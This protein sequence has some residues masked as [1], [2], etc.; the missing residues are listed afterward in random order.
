MVP[1][2]PSDA[3]LLV[4]PA[5]VLACVFRG[6]ESQFQNLIALLFIF[7]FFFF[8]LSLSVG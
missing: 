1:A 5:S 6:P 7:V 8:F 3:L 4:M 2:E